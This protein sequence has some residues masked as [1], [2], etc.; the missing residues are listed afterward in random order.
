M[1]KAMS[2][3]SIP[4]K[5]ACIIINQ[6]PYPKKRHRTDHNTKRKVLHIPENNDFEM[7]MTELWS[8]NKDKRGGFYLSFRGLE[9]FI[10]Y[11]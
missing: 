9:A 8:P 3:P 5:K 7:D 11:K 2:F 4:G 6:L 1:K 10:K